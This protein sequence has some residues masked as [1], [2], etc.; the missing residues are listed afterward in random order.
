[1]PA[2]AHVGAAL[3][4]G[5]CR[6]DQKGRWRGRKQREAKGSLDDVANDCKFLSRLDRGRKI[7][8]SAR[9]QPAPCV[10]GD[11]ADAILARRLPCRGGGVQGFREIKP[12]AGR[13]DVSFAG[14]AGNEPDGWI[15]APSHKSFASLHAAKVEFGK[16][17]PGAV[18][19]GRRPASA[20]TR[21]GEVDEVALDRVGAVRRQHQHLCLANGLGRRPSCPLKNKR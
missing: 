6:G 3:Q 14:V 21:R 10:I 16:I 19:V 4:R 18:G 2:A 5:G 8:K 17:A 20:L 12:E 13:E 11:T 9:G 15:T 7:Q 1:M